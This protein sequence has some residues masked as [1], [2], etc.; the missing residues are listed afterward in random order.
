[1]TEKP[2]VRDRGGLAVFML[3]SGK[4]LLSVVSVVVLALTWYGWQFVGSLNEGLATTNVFDSKPQA[5]PLDGAIDILLVGQD[6]RTDNDGNPLPR[7]V[8]DQLHAGKADGQR[9]TDTMILVHIPQDGTR[10][11]AI[12]FP[13]D[14]WVEINGGY[15]THKLN[16]A[17]AYAYNDTHSTLMQQGEDDLKAIDERAK[18]A[19]RKNLIATIEQ[20]VGKPGLIDRYAEV[21]LASFY[22]ITNA[23]G[24]IEVCLKE[25]VKEIRSGIDLPAGRQTIEGVQALAFVRQRYELENYDLDR[26]ARQQAF[27]SGLA[28]KVISTDVLTSPSKI[29]ELVSAVKKSVVLSEDWDLLE[30]AGQ[31]RGLTGGNIEFRTIPVVGNA[32]IGGA[33]VV[34][35]DVQ[36]VQ[37]FVDEVIGTEGESRKDEGAIADIAGAESITV[38]LFNASGVSAL[39]NRVRA[40]LDSAG[41]DGSGTTAIATRSST[42]VRHPPGEGNSVEALSQVLGMSL[43]GEPDTDVEAGHVRLLL[44]TDYSSG[45]SSPQGAAAQQPPETDTRDTGGDATRKPIT[46]GDVT[47]VN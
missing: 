17:F 23:I 7:E 15:G 21:N 45:S 10:A 12:S 13:R 40:Q 16:S 44:G 32:R 19:G 11:V 14:S 26:I 6:S 5:V 37:T 4:A 18:T 25:P 29:S 36:Q 31:M 3:Y 43:T 46:A 8:L 42:V 27:L 41:F 35:V 24:G 9:S 20:F 33:D 47:C 34:E 28:R 39:G 22:E 1:M 38:E 2:V 30:F